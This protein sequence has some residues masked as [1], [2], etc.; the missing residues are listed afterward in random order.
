MIDKIIQ[1]LNNKI[2]RRWNDME[3][4]RLEINEN[5]DQIEILEKLNIQYKEEIEELH[6]IIVNLEKF[7]EE[8]AQKD[9]E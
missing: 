6:F 9:H 7:K 2:S 4:H 5:K 3:D 8:N 1:D